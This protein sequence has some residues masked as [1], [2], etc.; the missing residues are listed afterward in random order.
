MKIKRIK[1]L[2]KKEFFQI[3][4][5]PSSILIA[6]IFPLILLFIYGYGISLDMNNLK[7]GLIVEDTSDRAI[8]LKR[9][10]LDSKF[11]HVY[12]SN[13]EKK[14][15]NDLI[16]FKIH[17]IIKIPFYFSLYRENKDLKGPIFVASDGSSPNTAN[18]VQNYAIGAWKNFLVQ[19]NLSN[20][21][22]K[23]FNIIPVPRFWYNEEL[24]SRYF[25]VPG[26]IAIIMTLIGTL[27]TALVVA[28]EWE[29]GTMEAV[30]ATPVT[31]SEFLISKMISYFCLGIGSMI[32]STALAIFFFDLPFRGSF[33]ALF[34]VSSVFLIVALGTGLL[35]SIL[36][37]N[38]FIAS[39]ISIVAAFLPSFM[40]SGFIFEISSMPFLIRV[41]T[42]IIPAKYMVSALQS[43]FL[44]GTVWKLLLINTAILGLLAIIL[45]TA[46]FFKSQKR[47]D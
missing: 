13:N 27:L 25:L 28:R 24:N 37:K 17:G 41:L 22:K 23:N 30:M 18:F 42:T 4:K 8:S 12:Q 35:I 29:R 34:I 11:F 33:F 32:F 20:N 7:V 16:A 36:S 10:F 19:D 45:I 15:I 26:S 21:S 31:M 9:S 2:I 38:Q 14:L 46:I 43:L 1:A 39:Q 44:V 3:I 6:L 5:D 40:L 47:I